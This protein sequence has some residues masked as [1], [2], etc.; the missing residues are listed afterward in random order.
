MRFIATWMELKTLI[1]SEVSW[2][3]KDR[4]YRYHL[5]VESKTW[6][7]RS[8]TKQKQI[9]DMEDTPVVAI[10]VRGSGMD[11]ESGVSR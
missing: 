10:G 6:H 7:K 3:Q 8:T 11:W 4:Q 5:H 1:Q 2:K 9:M